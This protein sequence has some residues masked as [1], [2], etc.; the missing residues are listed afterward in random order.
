MP[1]ETQILT[2]KEITKT[3][4]ALAL[5]IRKL[6]KLIKSNSKK[7]ILL[8][9]EDEKV[10]EM[11]K[12]VVNPFVL[13]YLKEIPPAKPGEPG[14]DAEITKEMLDGVCK[15]AISVIL[16]QLPPGE[17]GKDAEITPQV[18]QRVAELAATLVVFPEKSEP[19][20]NPEIEKLKKEIEDLK[21]V[22]NS[23]DDK[24]ILAKIE[25]LNERIDL[26][27]KQPSGRGGGGMSNERVKKII[28]E[29]LAKTSTVL[30]W[31][32]HATNV[33]YSNINGTI[34]TGKVLTGTVDGETVYRF[35]ST[36][37]TG[38]YPTEDSFYKTFDGTN[39]SALIVTK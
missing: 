6:R 1:K 36:A 38:L 10:I 20:D 13:K 39:L 8:A 25:K 26:N 17:P 23:F 5:E 32:Y 16:K 37:K 29:E 30:D 31:G 27:N 9:L 12:G 7:E 22:D 35:I 28:A 24:D 18:I 33:K 19:K 2:P 34:P 14:K 15:E 11:F 4:A 3:F 21:K